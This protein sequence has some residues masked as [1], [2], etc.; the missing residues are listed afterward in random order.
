VIYVKNNKI[1]KREREKEREGGRERETEKKRDNHYAERDFNTR[2]GE[3]WAKEEDG[4][5]MKDRERR[6][7]ER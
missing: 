7:S 1:E 4:R 5:R 2:T 6:E 3:E